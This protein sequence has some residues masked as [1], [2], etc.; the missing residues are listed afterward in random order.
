MFIIPAGTPCRVRRRDSTLA[1]WIEWET[2]KRWQFDTYGWDAGTE[3]MFRYEQW[4]IM[5]R[6]DLIEVEP[7]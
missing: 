3:Y 4:F 5:V 6:K 1:D 2:T 7:E